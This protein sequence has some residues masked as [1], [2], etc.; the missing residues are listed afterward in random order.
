MNRIKNGTRIII[1]MIFGPIIFTGCDGYDADRTQTDNIDSINTKYEIASEDYEE[2]A[3][4]AIQHFVDLDFVSWGEM[5]ANDVSFH[6]PDGDG[7]NR[8]ILRGKDVVLTWFSDWKETSGIE[9]MTMI[10]GDHFPIRSK[11]TLNYSELNDVLVISYFSNHM[12]YNGT[13]INL[14]MNLVTFINSENKIY[15]Y[16]SYYDRTDIVNLNR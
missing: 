8:T 6:F 2:L 1:S 12:I 16:Y 4:S 13:P 15:R 11:E 3:A 10:N 5:L 7:E 9:K 14:R